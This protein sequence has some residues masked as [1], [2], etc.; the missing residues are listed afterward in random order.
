[1]TL[2]Y[3]LDTTFNG[4]GIVWVDF[5]GNNNGSN[6]GLVV[7]PNGKITIS[8][9]MW[10]GNNYD[11]AVYRFNANG[12]L[13][14]TFSGDGKVNF[15]FGVGKNDS[16]V[17]LVRQSNGK[18]IV[19][20]SSCT[21]TCNFALARLNGNGTL[22]KT[23]SGDGKQITNMGADDH[24]NA[25]AL[26]A[27]GKIVVAGDKYTGSPNYTGY[28]AVARYNPDGSLDTTFHGNGRFIFKVNSSE[29]S[30]ASDVPSDVLIQPNKK[31][32]LAGSAINGGSFDFA[33]VRLNS[34]GSFDTTF[35][36]NGKTIIDF[37]DDD[38]SSTIVLQ[39][40]DGKYVLGGG[41]YNGSQYNFAIAR[42]L[43]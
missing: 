32:I 1:V 16:A 24:I 20:G 4:T 22:D 3:C 36:G 10:N 43:P 17:D 6:G 33:L 37:G 13:D 18:L 23:F 19:V 42:V 41:S 14:T 29:N 8:G 35:N 2:Q 31:I 26:Q 28:F 38:Y 40:L 27:D 15:G 21:T 11:F 25:V 9:Y 39:P 7:T 5:G 34:N 30:F 12:T